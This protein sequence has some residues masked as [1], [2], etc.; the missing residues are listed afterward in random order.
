MHNACFRR[1][2]AWDKIGFYFLATLVAAVIVIPVLLDD[3][4]GLEI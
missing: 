3:Y 2:A 1:R 4:N